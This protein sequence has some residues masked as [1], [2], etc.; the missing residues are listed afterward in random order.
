MQL[1]LASAIDHTAL[2]L[3]LPAHCGT[4]SL[5]CVPQLATPHV[6]VL[7]MTMAARVAMGEYL[8]K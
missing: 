5:Q 8:I 6:E 4:Y 3:P 7:D 1:N 2:A